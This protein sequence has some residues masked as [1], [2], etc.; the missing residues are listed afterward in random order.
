MF[1]QR[2]FFFSPFMLLPPFVLSLS[3]LTPPPSLKLPF[4]SVYLITTMLLS[5][6]TLPTP[7]LLLLSFPIHPT[8]TS[9]PTILPFSSPY[10][11]LIV[12][13]T[14]IPIS[15]LHHNRH[16]YY[17]Y[18]NPTPTLHPPSLHSL[19]PS[20]SSHL[21]HHHNIPHDSPPHPIA[22][23]APHASSRCGCDRLDGTP[24]T[25]AEGDK[26]GRGGVIVSPPI[27]NFPDGGL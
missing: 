11:H 5:L 12:V 16:H 22:A 8:F 4:T 1:V 14:I 3:L 26:E 25:E 23:A 21:H 19:S 13:V 7:P 6:P 24:F 15:H 10:P 18:L 2:D 17:L 9:L 20:S 27:T